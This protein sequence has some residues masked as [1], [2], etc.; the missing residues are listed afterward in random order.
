MS[1]Q[2]LL[3]GFAPPA[4]PTDR[5][6]FAFM[7][8]AAAAHAAEALSL[9]LG[10]EQGIKPRAHAKERFH[11]TLFHVGDFDGLPLQT[12]GRACKA[13]EH[14][15]AAPLPIRFDRVTSFRGAPRR[16]PV[17]L[18]GHDEG[19]ALDGFHDQLETQMHRAGLVEPGAR[20]R[21]TPHMTLLY[22]HQ[23]VPEQAIE[24]INWV[25]KEFVLIRSLIGQGRYIVMERWPL[26]PASEA[27]RP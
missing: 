27:A 6:F 19:G 13:A 10:G 4:A 26:L 16:L 17:I 8:D 15:Q 3:D 20:R 25:A 18:L 24:P 2:G 12:I 5:L 1:E 22:G 23:S 14:V 21:F 7:P 11:V 9:K